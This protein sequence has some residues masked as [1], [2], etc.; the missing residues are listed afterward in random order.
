MAEVES[1]RRM[2]V[3]NALLTGRGD[4]EDEVSH[5]LKRAGYL[6]P[7][8]SFCVAVARSADPVEMQNTPRAQRVV[9]AVSAAVAPLK[10]RSVAGIRN[11][12]ATAVFADLRRRSGWEAPRTALAERVRPSL[13]VL[14]PSVLVG[15]S[16]DQPSIE[17]IPA[18]LEEAQIALNC[19]NVVDRVVQFA[20]LS[21][22][23]LA[24]HF[25]GDN[26]R[27][28]LPAWVPDFVKADEKS[29]GALSRTLHAYAD[30]DMNAI[31]TAR[32]LHVHP[33]T[34]YAR[35]RRIHALTGLLVQRYHDLTELLLTVDSQRRLG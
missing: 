10:I 35:M 27:N 20:E 3:L 4:G 23:R 18:A 13:L 11:N 26:L 32:V 25:C 31:R 28:A 17:L 34:L 22:R 15:L 33:N 12:V 29:K 24:L 7:R 21:I 1:D 6:A 16:R 9:E 8:Q 30:S 19:A 2:D 5:L 14:G